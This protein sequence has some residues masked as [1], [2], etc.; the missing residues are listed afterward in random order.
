MQERDRSVELRCYPR[1]DREF[2]NDAQ[3]AVAE[4]RSTARQAE[5]LVAE[6]QEKLRRLYPRARVQRREPIAE[7]MTDSTEIWYCYRDGGWAA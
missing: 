1:G 6:V 4:C 5:A 7:L 3:R 2:L